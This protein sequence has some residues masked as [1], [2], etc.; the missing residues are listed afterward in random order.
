MNRE[1]EA[2]VLADSREHRRISAGETQNCDNKV[3]GLQM[4]PEEPGVH[5][6]CKLLLNYNS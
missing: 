5:Q 2:E 4:N 3:E 1:E 6:N